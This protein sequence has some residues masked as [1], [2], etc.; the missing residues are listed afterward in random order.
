MRTSFRSPLARLGAPAV[1]V[2]ALLVAGCGGGGADSPDAA[3]P[4]GDAAASPAPAAPAPAPAPVAV[5][6]AAQPPAAAPA[7]VVSDFKW[8]LPPGWSE[9]AVPADNPMSVA[10][11]ELGRRLFY[12]TRLSG[13]GRLSCAFCH[14][15]S[16]GFADGQTTPFG[17]AGERLAR[18]S[19]PLANLAWLGSLTWWNDTVTTLETQM[20]AP[21]F[22]THPVE[23]GVNDL[24]R[25]FVLARFENDADDRARFAAAFPADPAA[26][27]WPNAIRA[28]AAFQRTLV[29]ADSRHDRA[30][31]GEAV[32][33]AEESRGRDLFFSDRAG[34]S[35]CHGGATFAEPTRLRGVPVATTFHNIGLYDVDGAGAYPE[36]TRGL[37][38]RTGIATDMGRFR[39][40]SL[41]NVEV[42]MPYMHDG[43]VATLA[44]VIEIKAAGGR[45]NP[46][47]PQDGD[48][49]ANPYKS[50]LV[51]PIDLTNAEKADLLAF[52]RTLTDPTFLTNPAFSN[53]FAG[54]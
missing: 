25:A 12:D 39:T 34:C 28:I 9:P 44:E 20:E 38:D 17:G 10:K 40:P 24:N 6:P 47:R 21:L 31:R 30:L 49:R 1:I 37:I 13:D 32:L 42:T 50:P 16:F 2:A 7:P 29:S 51:A 19:Q 15:Q 46:A 18:N 4:A 41:R 35:G 14:R 43:S 36:A 48:G 22:A 5:T 23:M 52:L 33:S 27:S 3:L 8:A 11:V 53:P 26:V 54:P 45:W